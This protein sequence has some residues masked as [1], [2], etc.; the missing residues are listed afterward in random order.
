MHQYRRDP[1]LWTWEPAAAVVLVFG[2]SVT[3]GIHFGRGIACLLSGGGFA[4]PIREALFSSVWPLLMGDV[5]AGLAYPVQVPSQVLVVSIVSSLCVVAALTVLCL[6][7][8]VRRWGNGSLKGV[9][10]VDEVE[11]MLGRRR[12]F[13]VRNVVRPDLFGSRHRA[14]LR[15]HGHA[16]V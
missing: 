16:T 7:W 15:E 14:Q 3:L 5:G 8:A 13:R 1:Y 11:Q 9:A 4:W 6:V 12:L 10:P 2:V